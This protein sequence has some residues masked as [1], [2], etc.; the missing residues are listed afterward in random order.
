MKK[1]GTNQFDGG[2]VAQLDMDEWDVLHALTKAYS[3]KS[4]AFANPSDGR[5]PVAAIRELAKGMGMIKAAQECMAEVVRA[6]AG[7]QMNQGRDS[8]TTGAGCAEGL[9]L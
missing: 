7:N 3:D 9:A 1:L 6:L 8:E 4:M 2:V 5:L